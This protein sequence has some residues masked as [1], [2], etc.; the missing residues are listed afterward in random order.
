MPGFCTSR[1]ITGN[2][3][4]SKDFMFRLTEELTFEYQSSSLERANEILKVNGA[5]K[6]IAITKYVCG[7]CSESIFSI[8]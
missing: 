6:D 8:C 7:K 3:I 1:S 5:N 4:S 2:N